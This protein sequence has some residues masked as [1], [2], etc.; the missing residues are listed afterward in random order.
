MNKRGTRASAVVGVEGVAREAAAGELAT[1]IEAVD[2]ALLA[3]M[4]TRYALI[5]ED[6]V[7]TYNNMMIWR[8]ADRIQCSKPA[9]ESPQ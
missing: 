5:Y 7:R 3:V 2:T 4:L 1:G 9:F 6:K 8:G